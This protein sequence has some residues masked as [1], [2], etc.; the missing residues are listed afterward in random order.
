[1]AENNLK[2]AIP[3]HELKLSSG[4]IVVFYD[5][6]TTGES[7]Q[8]QKLL[9]AGGK[10]NAE[11]GKIED[12]PIDQFLDIQDKSAESVIKEVKVAEAD[13][14]D[15]SQDWLNSLPVEVGNEVYE[16]VNR[17]TQVSNLAKE[18]KKN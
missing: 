8:L 6:L 7:R 1:M 14:V 12:L 9:L 5:Y 17:I 4:D 13:A 3:T 11:T 10:F 18:E 15:F 16:E 2:I